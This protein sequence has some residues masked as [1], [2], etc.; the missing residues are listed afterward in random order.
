MLASIYPE[1]D[2][3][4]AKIAK[5]GAVLI[6]GES[7]TDKLLIVSHCYR[8]NDDVIHIIICKTSDKEGKSIL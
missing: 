7:M 2:D 3:T 4:Y 6:I 5:F 1:F 8:D